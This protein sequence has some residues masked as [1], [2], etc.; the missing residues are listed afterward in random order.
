MIILLALV[1]MFDL[2]Q[3][4]VEKIKPKKILTNAKNCFM[5]IESEF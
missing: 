5:I 4:P 2:R 1:F 3:F